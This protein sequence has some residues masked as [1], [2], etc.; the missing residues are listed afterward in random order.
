MKVEYCYLLNGHWT[1]V[2]KEKERG[3][4]GKVHIQTPDGAVL[5]YFFVTELGLARSDYF[6]GVPSVLQDVVFEDATLLER[7]YAWVAGGRKS[8]PST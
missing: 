6:I 2:S 4:D 7:T 5:D 3:E 1:R 8:P